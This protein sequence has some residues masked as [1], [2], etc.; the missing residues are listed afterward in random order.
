MDSPAVSCWEE[1]SRSTG[2]HSPRRAD[3]LQGSQGE[4][5][6]GRQ[7]GNPESV[8]NGPHDVAAQA[9]PARGEALTVATQPEL[10]ERIER[11]GW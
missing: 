3:N 2:R 11:L 10:C 1:T 5:M 4:H 7:S 9:L 6:S 8:S